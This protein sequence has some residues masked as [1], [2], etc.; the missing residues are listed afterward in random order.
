MVKGKALHVAA[1][2]DI[3]GFQALNGW[4]NCF[5]KIHN[6]YIYKTTSGE[7]ATV[8]PKTVMDWKS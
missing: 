8:N 3:N 4:I 6:L 2:Q 5:K 1:N 7:S